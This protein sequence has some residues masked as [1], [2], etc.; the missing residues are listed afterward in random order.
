M[1]YFKRVRHLSAAMLTG[2]TLVAGGI[3]SA[4]AA[5]AEDAD[6]VSRTSP[7]GGFGYGGFVNPSS[8]RRDM[9]VCDGGAKDGRRAVA[10]L[11]VRGT[12]YEVHAAGGTGDCQFWEDLPTISTG[13][14][15][16]FRVCLRNGP[17][18]TDVYCDTWQYGI[19]D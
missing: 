11:E 14:S 7:E 9:D 16:R 5:Y 4:P 8:D 17:G 12:R 13:Q 19:V 18:G 1:K 3:V 10:M 2:T 15:F 6:S